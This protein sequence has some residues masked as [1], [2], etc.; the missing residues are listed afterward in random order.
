MESKKRDEDNNRIN[1]N[2]YDVI[3][4]K[5]NKGEW[6]RMGINRNWECDGYYNVEM[7]KWKEKY[8]KEEK[9]GGSEDRYYSREDGKEKEKNS[10]GKGSINERR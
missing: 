4:R 2:R 8:I 3:K 10:E 7:G 6:G 5:Y 1:C 9:K